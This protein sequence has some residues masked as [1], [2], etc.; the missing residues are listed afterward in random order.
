MHEPVFPRRHS[1]LQAELSDKTGTVNIP[2][3]FCDHGYRLVGFSELFLCFL[4]FHII[5]INDDRFANFVLIHF[6]IHPDNYLS[7]P[8][9]RSLIH[10]KSGYFIRRWI[11][12]LYIIPSFIF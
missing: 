2:D 6:L 11:I 8:R 10:I 12:F 3:A 1:D 4:N 9:F 5:E 7:F